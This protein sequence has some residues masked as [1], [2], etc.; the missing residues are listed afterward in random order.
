MYQFLH[1]IRY[2]ILS[3]QQLLPHPALPAPD[4]PLPVHHKHSAVPDLQLPVLHLLSA[5]HMLLHWQSSLHHLYY[6]LHPVLPVHRLLPALHKPDLPLP[7][8][9]SP[10]PDRLLPVLHQLSPV[11]GLHNRSGSGG[12]RSMP[13]SEL[14]IQP[15]LLLTVPDTVFPVHPAM[16]GMQLLLLQF[17]LL[18]LPGSHPVEDR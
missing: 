3:G 4:L 13:D 11:P 12:I 10:V 17:L 6:M 8:L 5:V 16:P 9:L 1:Q 14:P 15:V 7:D 18:L 2:H